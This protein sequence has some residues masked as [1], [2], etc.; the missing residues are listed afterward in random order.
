MNLIEV[1]KQHDYEILKLNRGKANPI[2]NDLVSAIRQ[3]IARIK[4]DDS[5]RGVILTGNTDGFF[6][7]GLDLKELYG[8]DAT[9]IGQFFENWE[10][11]VMEL[12]QFPKPIIAAINGYSP[13]GGCVLAILCD[14][15]MMA[16][17]DKFT[18]G[19][20]EVAAGI[21]V[22]EYIFQVYSF[23]IGRRQAYHYLTRGKL[24]KVE[25]ALA[26]N[27]VDEVHEM[28]DLLPKAEQEMQRLLRLSDNL[29]Q[30]TKL[31]MRAELIGKLG[32]LLQKDTKPM[33]EAWFN[34]QSRAIMKMLVDSISKK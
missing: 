34:P 23:W 4:A 22:P 14:Y 8:Y 19:L 33:V 21:V 3:Q 9:Q 31:N 30:Q 7:V 18:I 32:N 15:R 24:L 6:S 1:I 10:A 13:A 2:N 16:K 5:A 12:I 26:C 28:E 25:E 27:L 17:G 20:N 29:L 11:M